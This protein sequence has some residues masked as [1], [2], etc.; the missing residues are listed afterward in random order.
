M[1]SSYSRPHQLVARAALIAC[2]VL[3]LAGC[4]YPYPYGYGYGGYTVY[5]GAP[6]A[7]GYYA[8]AGASAGYPANSGGPAAG[9]YYPSAGV[10]AGYPV[11]LESAE[12]SATLLR[13]VTC[14]HSRRARVR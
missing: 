7:G 12:F 2:L 8:T 10:S 14:A 11:Y 5:S 13:L 3:V 6:A 4:V 1:P 9:G